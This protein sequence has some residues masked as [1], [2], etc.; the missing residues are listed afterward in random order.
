MQPREG[1]SRRR[2]RDGAARKGSDEG[3]FRRKVR[4]AGFDR[5]VF[6]RLER[7]EKKKNRGRR[8]RDDSTARP[9]ARPDPFHSIP[10]YPFVR[11]A[12]NHLLHHARTALVV[13]R[14]ARDEDEGEKKRERERGGAAVSGAFYTLVTIRPRWRCGRRSLRTLPGVSLRPHHGFNPR[15]R[16]LSTPFDAFQLHPD[17]RSYRTALRGA[18]AGASDA[19]ARGEGDA[20]RGEELR[21]AMR[22]TE[23]GARRRDGR[24]TRR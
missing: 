14:G 8:R 22:S 16:R 19:V 24:Q 18:A 12:C 17:V 3:V 6:S 1:A 20:R 5:R 7:V 15:L 4:R 9:T 10:F 21:R 2:D 13:V 23:R 11:S